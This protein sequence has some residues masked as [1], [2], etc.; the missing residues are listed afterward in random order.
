MGGLLGNLD[1]MQTARAR[2]QASCAGLYGISLREPA[3]SDES[4]GWPEAQ[5]RRCR[6]HARADRC[7]KL[8][9][10]ENEAALLM[11]AARFNAGNEMAEQVEG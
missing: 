3:V 10:R 6:V 8:R 2:R 4:T 11:D 7:W 1:K 5:K 9:R